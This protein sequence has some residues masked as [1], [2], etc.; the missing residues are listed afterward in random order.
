M[1]GLRQS[2]PRRWQKLLQAIVLS[3]CGASLLFRTTECHAEPLAGRVASGIFGERVLAGNVAGVRQRAALLPDERRF[4]LLLKWVLPGDTH[5]NYRMTGEFTQTL[6]APVVAS[7]GSG[8]DS[9]ARLVSPVFDL[10]DEARRTGRLDDL[11]QIVSSLEEPK[12]RLRYRARTALL[13][14]I[15][16]ELQR[17]AEAEQYFDAFYER[18]ASAGPA[19][20]HDQWPETLLVWRIVKRFPEFVGVRDLLEVLVV[21]RVQRGIPKGETGWFAHISSLAR[22]HQFLRDEDR[23]GVDVSSRITG[24][25]LKNWIP[26]SRMRAHSRGRGYPVDSWDWDGKEARHIG[27]HDGD[28]LF[29]RC[30]L[31]GNYSVEADLLVPREAQ[32]LTAGV[33]FGP[34]DRKELITGQFGS[35]A[36][37]RPLDPHFTKTGLWVHYRA[38]INDGKCRTWIH[39]RLV[40]ER[41]LPDDHDPW[42]G[43]RSTFQ[44]SGAVRDVRITG[45]PFIPESIEVSGRACRSGW[46]AYHELSA[47]GENARWKFFDGELDSPDIVGARAVGI[48][49]S[50]RESLLRYHRPLVEDGVIEY[51]FYYKRGEV[52]VHPVLDRLAFL[53]DEEEVRLHWI[54][55]GRFDRSTL[56]PGNSYPATDSAQDS[57]GIPLE[58][59]AWNRMRLS[60][61]GQTVTLDL[62]G[63]E[64]LKRQL[65]PTNLRNFGLFHFA[66]QTE[67]RVRNVIMRGDWSRELP[68]V[69]EQQLADHLP[70]QLED[71]IARWGPVFLHDF[72]QDGLPEE[73][74]ELHAGAGL[75]SIAQTS[76]GVVHRQVGGGKYRT[77]SIG[78]VLQLRG[79]FDVSAVFDDLN[80]PDSRQCGCDLSLTLEGG[81]LFRA[82]RRYI[83]TEMQRVTVEWRI[84]SPPGTPA[85]EA[86]AIR[87]TWDNLPNEALGGKFRIAR[88]ADTVYVLFAEY[89]SNEFRV[90]ASQTYEG[91]SESPAEVKLATVAGK[92]GSAQVTWKRLR[93]AA[94]ELYTTPDPRNPPKKHLYVM[95]AD[96]TDLRQITFEIPEAPG[97]SHGSPDWSPTGEYIAFDAWTGRA[98]T[99]HAF[100]VRP[101]GTG[102][103]DLGIGAMP[104]FS[105]D[106][107]R[108]A[109][110]WIFNGMTTMNLDGE[111]RQVLTPDGWG[112]Q[113]SPDGKWVSYESRDRVNGQ[114]SANITIID[115]KTKAK[116][117]LLEGDLVTRYSQVYWNMEWAPDSRQ[118]VFKGSVRN[119]GVEVAIVSVD[120]SSKG[121]KVLTTEQTGTDFSWH[122]T[123]KSIFMTKNSPVHSG[124]RIFI[125]D[126][127][128]SELSLFKSQPMD[129]TNNHGVWSPDGKRVVFSGRPPMNARKW[130]PR[131]TAQ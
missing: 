86:G 5:P 93:I 11:Y 10:L 4:D 111:D 52:L 8:T 23:T 88:R 38:E 33:F 114:Y 110:T 39:G 57:G 29:F 94:E 21:G 20:M 28:Y 127:A 17:D 102:L 55:D 45:T 120:G 96:G 72:G 78:A 130:I 9:G 14:M 13:I 98:E 75:N 87:R 90:V 36:I 113:W 124:T 40:D 59:E 69:S 79:D 81:Y 70:Q 3:L 119:G 66:D 118:I 22:E 107:K 48:D 99:S 100:I 65:E 58:G 43:V 131:S 1:S 92:D 84:P 121:F 47:A 106:G 18:V 115:V 74:F 19:D 53:L 101:D 7:E 2:R 104:N 125:F 41:Q 68:P 26:L 85:E 116:K 128:T 37:V 51:D 60:I 63:K 109:F 105:P 71:E 80:I 42:V 112:A 35:D 91:I 61:A 31:R 25:P 34:G 64:I 82:S 49:R 95:N 15:L 6:P 73:Y 32:F 46:Y 122:P 30:P 83:G 129:H 62:N 89:Q 117:T 50:F 44:R 54:T 67:A 123:G 27:G 12:N 56:P 16:L 126:L 77:S 103:K 76:A 97:T 108:L 24:L